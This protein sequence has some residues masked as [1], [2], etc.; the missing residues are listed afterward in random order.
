MVFFWVKKLMERW[1]LLISGK[2]LFWTFRR[3]KI[4]SFFDWKSWWKD[5]IYWLLKCSCFE[6]FGD[7][8]YRLFLSQKVGEKMIFTDYWKVPVFKFSGLK[9]T[10]FFWAEKLFEKWY[11]LINESFFF[12][13]FRRLKIRSIF[14]PKS[15]LKNV[16]SW[17]IKSSFFELFWDGKYVP[18]LSEKGDGKMIFTDYWKVLVLN[19]LGMG[20][21][22]IFWA[23]KLMKRWYL[24]VT[25]KFLFW[26]F[27]RWEIRSLFYPKSWWKGGIYWSLKSSCFE[28]FGD[29]KYG[30][31]L[32]Q[33]VAGK[34]IFTD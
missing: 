16:I 6:L 1:Y 2:F 27:Q 7:G 9:N 21:T 18:C 28:V 8:K 32:S 20:N 26:T 4:R 17:L 33:K 25:E 14:E 15:C 10:V 3:Y 23:K 34:M 19:F 13:S 5:D 29:E 24:L 12:R 22:F 11:L 31:F 30:V